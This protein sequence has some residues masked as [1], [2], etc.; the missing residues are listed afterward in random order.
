MLKGFKMSKGFSMLKNY[1]VCDHKYKKIPLE[2][3]DQHFRRPITLECKRA[4]V[5]KQ[6]VTCG[7]ISLDFK[8]YEELYSLGKQ[9]KIYK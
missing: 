3:F 9:R 1:T 7:K 8:D 4:L 2:D 5:L 6:C